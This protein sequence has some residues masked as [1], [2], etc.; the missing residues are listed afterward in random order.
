MAFSCPARQLTELVI[1]DDWPFPDYLNGHEALT[2]VA[3]LETL[4]E[5]IRPTL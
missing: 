1:T 2:G 3:F 5:N 4:P